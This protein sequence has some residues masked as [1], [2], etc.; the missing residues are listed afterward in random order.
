MTDWLSL[1]RPARRRVWGVFALIALASLGFSLT[2]VS[3]AGW[4]PATCMPDDCF[5]EAIRPGP[6][7]QPV[8]A[9]SNLAFV[10]VGLLILSARPAAGAQMRASLM[11][12]QPAYRIVF[13]ASTVVIGLGSLFYHASLSFAGQWFDVMGMY[14]LATFMALYG[15]ARIRP[16]RGPRFALLYV[17]VNGVLGALL[18]AVPEVRRQIFAGLILAVIALEGWIALRHRPLM[19]YGYF[20]AALVSFA[21]AYAIWLLDT[22]RALCAPDSLLQGHALWHLL[23]ALAA[24]LI[25]AYYRSEQTAAPTAL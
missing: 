22:A 23:G 15:L 4:R 21:V 1:W 11:L 19:R 13:G 20:G 18:I 16:L 14:L 7:A 6:I 8:N 2:D 10:L 3:W 5:C 24:S 17:A 12:S 25:Y 9:W